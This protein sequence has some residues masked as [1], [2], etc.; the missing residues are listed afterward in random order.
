MK[1]TIMSILLLL[2]FSCLSLAQVVTEA[3]LRFDKDFEGI[4]VYRKA[5]TLPH[6]SLKYDFKADI[7]GKRS[8]DVF[9]IFYT[10]A[11][12][13]DKFLLEPGF[14][15]LIGFD[16]DDEYFFDIYAK[17]QMSKN[18]SLSVEVGHGFGKN[19]APRSYMFSRLSHD[20]FL[21]EGGLVTKKGYSSWDEISKE[22]YY[23]VGFHPANLFFAVGN[24][25][26]TTWL[27]ASTRDFTDFGTLTFLSVDRSTG[28]F[29]MRSQVGIMEASTGFFS[30]KTLVD[31]TSYLI[32]TPFHYKHFSPASTKGLYSIKVDARK[33]GQIERKEVLL[34]RQFGQFGQLSLGVQTEIGNG[35]GLAVEYFNSIAAGKITGSIELRHET[36]TKKLSAFM[37][38]KY[39]L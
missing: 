10:E 6:V 8:D 1:T 17:Y 3:S 16:E 23:W 18:V 24:N 21:L 38:L 31:A 30:L 7:K 5:I 32:V 20:L 35:Y 33:V 29:W 37:T 11:I 36:M 25:V 26:G 13:T 9:S 39:D 28:D 22:K 34:G 19:Q 14:I 12:K 4:D 2:L 27:V 15:G